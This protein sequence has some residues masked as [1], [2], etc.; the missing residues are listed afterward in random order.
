MTTSIAQLIRRSR[1][2][3]S[4]RDRLWAVVIEE[5]RRLAHTR[6][7]NERSGH[8]LET[9]ALVNEVFLKL[10]QAEIDINN[11]AHFMAIA[12][13]HL[14]CIL[15]DYAR[16]NN[17]AKRG[18]GV[19]HITLRD[20]GNVSKSTRASILDLHNALRSLEAKDE[21][22]AAVVELHYFGGLSFNDIASALGISIAT[23]TRKMRLGK[24]MLI[25]HLTP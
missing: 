15:V 22:T 5:L 14:R 2:D 4:A 16:A 20:V 18:G 21:C 3:Q 13:R 24:A 23:V 19:R 10:D 12:A 25:K 9:D 7:S 11:R 6:L 17:C 1:A 8:T